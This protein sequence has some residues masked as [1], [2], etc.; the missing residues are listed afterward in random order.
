MSLRGA[1]ILLVLPQLPQDPASGAAR[2][3]RTMCEMLAAAGANL[4]FGA[5]RAIHVIAVIT[6]QGETMKSTTELTETAPD[7]TTET[8]ANRDGIVHVISRMK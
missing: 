6:A 5:F 7:P 2:S 1:R 4:A 8:K 3:T